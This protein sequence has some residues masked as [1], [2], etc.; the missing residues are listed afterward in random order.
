MSLSV[1]RPWTQSRWASFFWNSIHYRSQKLRTDSWHLFLFHFPQRIIHHQV[2]LILPPKKLWNPFTSFIF[3]SNIIVQATSIPH[4][5]SCTWICS[6]GSPHILS[7]LH[8]SIHH[9]VATGIFG[10][11]NL[12]NSVLC[13]MS[14]ASHHFFFFCYFLG[15]TRGIWRFPG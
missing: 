3:P 6:K 8:L 14:S 12:M 7:Y 11:T 9:D 10:N 2:L 13:L 5:N 1:S 15:R 4:L